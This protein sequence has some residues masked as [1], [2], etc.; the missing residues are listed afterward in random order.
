[1]GSEGTFTV[2][3]VLVF[4]QKTQLPSNH[5][6]PPQHLMFPFLLYFVSLVLTTM[7]NNFT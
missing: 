1:M 3:P 2:R 6:L 7:Q 5:P 4:L